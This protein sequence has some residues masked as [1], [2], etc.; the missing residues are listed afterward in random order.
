MQ[1]SKSGRGCLI[2]LAVVGAV[3]VVIGV[4]VAIAVWRFASAVDDV[5]DGITVGDVNCPSAEKVSDIV[6]HSVNLEMSGN[7]VV[8]SGCAYSSG[9]QAAGVS[10]VSGAG[11]IG[12]EVLAELESTAEANGTEATSIDEGEDGKAFGSPMRSEAATKADDHIVQVEIFSEG[13]D[14][15]GDKKD[16]AV[17]ILSLYLDLND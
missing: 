11:L 8:A 6:G 12:D 3:V 5:A 4:V 7:V 1:P 16:E 9:G 2:T 15:I 17:E 13:A 14:P 10:I